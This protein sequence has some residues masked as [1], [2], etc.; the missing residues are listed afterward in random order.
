MLIPLYIPLLSTFAGDPME[1]RTGKVLAFHKLNAVMLYSTVHEGNNPIQQAQILIPAAYSPYSTHEYQ[2]TLT[3]YHPYA[4]SM[5]G[6][7][8]LH[9]QAP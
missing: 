6:Q 1:A 9:S 4:Q 7:S 5:Y 8:Q 2:Q 3:P